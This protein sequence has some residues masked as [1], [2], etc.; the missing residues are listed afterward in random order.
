[1]SDQNPSEPINPKK[2]EFLYPHASYQGEFTPENLIFNA[3]LQEF[4][5]RIIYLCNLETNGKINQE[6]AY[7]EIRELWQELKASQNSLFEE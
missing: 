1:M 2:S 6:S 3:N 5:Q 7:Q 4:A